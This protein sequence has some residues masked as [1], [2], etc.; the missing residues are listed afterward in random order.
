MEFLFTIVICILSFFLHGLITRY[1]TRD[2][3]LLYIIISCII[4]TSI[5]LSSLFVLTL[6]ELIFANKISAQ[7]VVRIIS[8]LAVAISHILVLGALR[9]NVVYFNNV[10]P[11]VLA[12][13]A[14][15]PICM[16]LILSNNVFGLIYL[17]L[18]TL[19][20]INPSIIKD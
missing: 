4:F 5:S 12:R 3:I 11:T 18:F 7:Y 13:A 2:N 14:V 8:I 15:L 16:A 10:T 1:L 19:A 9:N 6:N 20:A 17:V